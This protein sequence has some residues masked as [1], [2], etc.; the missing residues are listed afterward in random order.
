LRLIAFASG[1]LLSRS[2]KRLTEQL[3]EIGYTGG[4]D[5]VRRHE[6]RWRQIS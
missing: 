5:A 3:R 4:Y 6:Q 1:S 2:T